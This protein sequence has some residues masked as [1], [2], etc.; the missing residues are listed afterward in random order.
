MLRHIPEKGAVGKEAR[1]IRGWLAC[2]FY[3]LQAERQVAEVFEVGAP[4]LPSQSDSR[5]QR[6]ELLFQLITQLRAY[7]WRFDLLVREN[8]ARLRLGGRFSGNGV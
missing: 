2:K 7:P 5:F 1:H 4:S 8:G 6:F 3:P